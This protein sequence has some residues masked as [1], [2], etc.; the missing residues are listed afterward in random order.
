MELPNRRPTRLQG[1]DYSNQNYYF[2][3]ICTHNKIPLFG[4][5]EKLN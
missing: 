3:T 2:V 4:D 1:Y 5:T